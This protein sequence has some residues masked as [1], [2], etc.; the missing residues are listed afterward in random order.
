MMPPLDH[1]K[2]AFATRK[3]PGHWVRH[4]LHPVDLLDATDFVKDIEAGKDRS[5]LFQSAIPYFALLTD[6]ARL[7]LFPD[8]L[9]TLVPYPHEIITMTGDLDDDRGQTLLAS[10][11]PT[12][13]DAIMQFIRSLSEQES[14]RPYSEDLSQLAGLVEASRTNRSEE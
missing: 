9:A 6:E 3:K 8:F 13:R 2:T 11:T 7:F 4:G 12:E 1:L 10:L 14:F 5:L